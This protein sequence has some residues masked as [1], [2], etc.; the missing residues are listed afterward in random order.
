MGKWLLLLVFVPALAWGQPNIN[1]GL[2]LKQEGTAL[3]RTRTLNCTGGGITCALSG[4]EG[5]LS[6]TGGGGGGINLLP[7]STCMPLTGSVTVFAGPGTCADPAQDSVRYQLT[8]AL[9]AAALR[10]QAGVS[11]TTNSLTVTIEKQTACSGAFVATGATCTIT[12]GTA[13][14][15]GT[16]VPI[17]IGAGG[18]CI[19]LR[20][21]PSGAF[22]TAAEVQCMVEA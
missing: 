19:A 18:D 17:S 12:V 16:G 10:C 5:T 7:V 2:I 1:Q 14:C 15:T 13:N 21:V 11:L 3:G 4:V 9:T 8:T 20:L 6:V 22:G